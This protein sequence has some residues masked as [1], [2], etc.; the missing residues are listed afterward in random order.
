MTLRSHPK[1]EVKGGSWEETPM[2]EARA[3]GWEEQPEERWM[4]RRKRA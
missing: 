1:P 4:P 3:S 2:P